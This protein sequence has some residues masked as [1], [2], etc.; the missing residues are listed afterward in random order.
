MKAY[1]ML[2]ALC[3]CTGISACIKGK[4]ID[5]VTPAPK[6]KLAGNWQLQAYTADTTLGSSS[7]VRTNA[8][9]ALPD[10]RQDDV[11]QF[12][13]DGILLLGEGTHECN[14]GMGASTVLGYW[15]ILENPQRLTMDDPDLPA[16]NDTLLIREL[17]DS[18]LRLENNI[19]FPAA[20]LQP[21]GQVLLQKTY[22]RRK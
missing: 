10:C 20:G 8:Y 1:S 4:S 11:F 22:Y 15:K 13:T 17:T 2:F 6:Q 14:P 18:V 21:Q 5:P 16:G 19:A 12:G 3:L 7:P 9:T